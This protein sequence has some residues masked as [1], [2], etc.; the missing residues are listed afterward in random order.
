METCNATVQEGPRKG[1]RCNFTPGENA[2]CGRHER[3]RIYDE[4][5]ANGIKWCRFF[6]RG[7]DTQITGDSLTCTPCRDKLCKKE[8]A[9][10][11][12]GCKF[13]I[14]E[15]KYCKK[16]TRDTYRDEE[17]EKNIKY[18]DIDRG[19]FTLV[20]D[21]TCDEC[22]QLSR[23]KDNER[24][25]KK[26]EQIVAEKAVGSLKRT[27]IGCSKEYEPF[28][29]H[30][31]KEATSCK[32]CL[33]KQ[34]ILDSKRTRVRDYKDE[35]CKNLEAY[36]KSYINDSMRRGHGDFQLNFQEFEKLVKSPCYYCKEISQINGIDR[37]NNDLGYT[38]DNCVT[39]CWT[40]NRMKHFYHPEFFL[41]K[42]KILTKELAPTKE[43]YKKWSLYYTRSNYKNYTAY[44]REAEESRDFAFEITQQQ[45]DWLTRSPCYLCGYQDAHGIG[46]DR[47]D[48]SIRK[49]TFDN[50]RPC[51]G[52]CNN[53]KNELS[54]DRVIEHARKVSETWPT[55]PF[56][57]IPVSRNPLKDAEDKGHY[58]HIPDRKHWKADGLYYAILS[59]NAGDFLEANKNIL[60]E[61]EFEEL[62]EDIVQ[63]EKETAIKALKKLL[64]KL[65]KRKVRLTP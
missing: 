31:N 39:A 37:V 4:G 35:K 60:T 42:C 32:E 41:N 21:K 47:V 34:K 18:C 15:G 16:H 65:K 38:A 1:N 48:N 61:R 3:N 55:N 8:I 27:C 64:V 57:T 50:C 51:C 22:L 29:T 54:F 63:S 52:S 9:C 5:I 17:K 58:V 59:N 56:N 13:K 28:N 43:F 30:H 62:C 25:K 45:W 2:Y 23:E 24:Y 53:M 40:C 10:G 49:Y 33:E 12:E 36:Y 11:H 19:C 6:F 46:L 26:K 7:C 14:L 20:K 44:K